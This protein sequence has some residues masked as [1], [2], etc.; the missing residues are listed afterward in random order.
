MQQAIMKLI[1]HFIKNGI[2]KNHNMKK[3]ND[4]LN[5]EGFSIVSFTKEELKLISSYYK[6]AF[7]ITE[8]RITIKN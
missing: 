3:I 8:N 7:I 6:T 1:Q 5:I 4:D 2:S